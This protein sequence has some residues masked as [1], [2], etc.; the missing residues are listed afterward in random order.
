MKKVLSVVTIAAAL[1][2]APAAMGQVALDFK[3]GC[4]IP[5]GNI[6]DASPANG[7]RSV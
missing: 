4:A 3:V 5:F 2:L 6:E 7:T 1:A